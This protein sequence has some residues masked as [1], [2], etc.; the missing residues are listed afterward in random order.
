MASGSDA[1]GLVCRIAEG[2]RRAEAELV[3]R[4]R[5]ALTMILRRRV[6]DAALAEDLCH[7]VF[8]IAIG[9]L[10]E[11][12]IL[13]GE[14]LTAY[15]LGIAR[16]VASSEARAERRVR[17][18]EATAADRTQA[19]PPDSGLFAA[20]RSRWLRKAMAT[21]SPRDHAVLTAFYLTDTPKPDICQRLGLTPAQF[22]LVKWRALKR[23][24]AALVRREDH[25][26]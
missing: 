11:R 25:R 26:G 12:R 24:L 19:P 3:E 14:K 5:A 2:D 15:L 17:T 10:R 7:E 20:E 21:L 8:T 18:A 22:D 16:N 6:K 1:A 23:L 9:A 13:D 4:Y